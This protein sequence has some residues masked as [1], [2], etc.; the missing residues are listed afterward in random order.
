MNQQEIRDFIE[1][2]IFENKLNYRRVSME[3]GKGAAY[4]QRYIK[5]GIPSHLPEDIRSKLATMLNVDEQLLSERPLNM[6]S[7]KALNKVSIDV[8]SANPCC[9]SG[10]DS[11]YSDEV[12]GKW[13]MP[14][15][16]FRELTF[17]KPEKIKQMRVIGDSMEPTIKDGDYILADTSF[18]SFD[19]D[20]IYL[21]RMFNGLAVKRIQ[22]GLNGIRIL[23]DNKLYEPITAAA[24]EVY[25]IG[26]VIKIMNI[27]NI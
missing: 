16:D 18:Q 24:G 15:D 20:G 14:I 13:I 11:D 26:K 21:I 27:K 9:G 8:I 5:R 3:L 23:S 17:A 22:A 1:K 2:K 4:M 7:F 25:V 10:N 6:M 19:V 12:V